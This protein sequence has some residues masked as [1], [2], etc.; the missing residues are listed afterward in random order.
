MR[1][2]NIVVNATNSY[3]ILG[4]RFIKNFNKF[5][6]GKNK[7]SFHFFSDDNPK[8]YV[9]IKNLIYHN[10]SHKSWQDATNSKFINILNI[11]N[12]LEENEYVY[13]FDADTN[14]NKY[15]TDEWFLDDIVGV[16]HFGNNSWMKDVKNYDRNPNSKAFIPFDTQHQ[17]IYFQGAC[18]GGIKNRV[19]DMCSQLYNNQIEDKKINYEPCV[20]D[21]SYINNYFHNNPPTKVISSSEFQFIVSDKGG[22]ENLR[23]PYTDIINLKNKLKQEFN[24]D[25]E[26]RNGDIIF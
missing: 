4:L 21:E 9:N 17:Q 2:I 20:N 25:F 8:D 24:K 15:F 18:F 10:T 5:Y 14:V 26:L 6:N 22:M 16:E 19:I 1:K 3:F 23:N 13:Y 12:L 11:S 7:I